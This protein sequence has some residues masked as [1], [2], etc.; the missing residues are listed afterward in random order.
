MHQ[1]QRLTE[2]TR[3]PSA[4]TEL[5]VQWENSDTV[6]SCRTVSKGTWWAEEKT[7]ASPPHAPCHLT[8]ER[9]I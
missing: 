8:R 2:N 3:L 1:T 5:T 4:P 7:L 9:F 6:T